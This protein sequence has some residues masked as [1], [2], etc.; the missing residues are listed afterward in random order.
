MKIKVLLINPFLTVYKD[1]P[2]GISPAL[3]LGYL[4]AYLESNGIEV[5]VLDIAAEGVNIQKKIGKK[6][7][8]GLLET[9]IFKRIKEFSPK[10]VGITCQSTLHAKEAM[11]TA[12]LVKKADKNILVVIG[13]AHPSANPIEVLKDENV[14][15]VVIG[16]GEVTFLEIT[17]RLEAKKNLNKIIG[18]FVKNGKKIIKNPGRPFIKDLDALPFPARH[19]L[20]MEIYFREMAKN[21]SY[22][23]RNRPMTVITSRGC[24]GNCIFCAVKTVWG[25]MW[26]G[27][28]PKNVVDEIEVLIKEY[29]A[30]EIHFIDD[31]ISVDKKRLEGICDEIIKRKLDIKWTT[32]NGIAV[33]LLDEKLLV[34]MKKAGCYRLTFGLESG[35]Y[36]TLN[37]FIGK[38]YDYDKAKQII[39]FASKIGLWTIGTFIIGF[40]YEKKD[41][42]EDTINFAIATDL[43]FAV[44]YIANPFPGTPMYEIYLK[45]KLL[46]S[47]NAFEVVRGCGTKYF[48]PKEL[49][50]IQGEAFSRFLESR[51]KNP[52]RFLNKI[53]SV[54]DLFYIIKLGKN[55]SKLFLNKTLVKKR[56]IAALWR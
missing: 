13:G 47:N 49:T 2:A 46:P 29:R 7:R 50:K 25:R 43:D 22:A 55:L 14:D 9:E 4:A 19:L 3:G 15:M 27:R 37:N 56:G 1:D 16:E 44:F 48:S 20:P 42:I 33:W 28:S 30:N 21:T 26:R 54:E 52:L 41:S 34:K 23:I 10:L 32:P 35:N 31:S 45:N 24:P 8:Y 40:P 39:N 5:K 53:R 6:V 36:E 12:E 11:E 51:R 17:Q 18:T 38:H